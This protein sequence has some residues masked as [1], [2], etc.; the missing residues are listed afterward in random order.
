MNEQEKRNVN[1]MAVVRLERLCPFPV[2]ELREAV[3][4]YK[5]AKSK[6]FFLFL[7]N[8]SLILEF[9]WSQEEPRNAG[10]WSF[11]N[12]RFWNSLGVQV[13]F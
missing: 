5:N 7:C 10:A 1:N 12:P 3:S 11:V 8:L 2:A 4:K 13:G 6:K 9:V